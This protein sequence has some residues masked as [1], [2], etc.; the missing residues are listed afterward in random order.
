MNTHN[1]K[2]STVAT[3][4]QNAK[5]FDVHLLCTMVKVKDKDFE[6]KVIR[7]RF[8]GIKVYENWRKRYN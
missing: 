3:R 6:R 4:P 8:E 5:C 7:R 1:F 2:I